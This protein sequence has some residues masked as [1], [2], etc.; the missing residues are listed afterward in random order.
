[1]LSPM[2]RN[3]SSEGLL[4]NS[5]AGNMSVPVSVSDYTTTGS[6]STLSSDLSSK[7]LTAFENVPGSMRGAITDDALSV[8]RNL[9]YG[10]LPG[11]ADEVFDEL[12]ASVSWTLPGIV[13]SP[14]GASTAFTL[15]V[16]AAINAGKDAGNVDDVDV[17]M[18]S[19]RASLT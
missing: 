12:V 18:K 1:M 10:I 8:R 5:A 16:D 15:N 17:A 14:A 9:P 7:N 6:H 19:C 4:V 2:S 13:E 11:A 3:T